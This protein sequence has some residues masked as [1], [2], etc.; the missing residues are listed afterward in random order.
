MNKEQQT[1]IKTLMTKHKKLIKNKQ[2]LT[3]FKEPIVFLIK[4]NKVTF[5]ENITE[6]TFEYKASNDEIRKVVLDPRYK[7]SF[8]YADKGFTGY[9]IDENHPTPIPTTPILSAES[10]HDVINRTLSIIDKW[11]A[12]DK[13]ATTQM[14]KTIGYITAGLIGMYILYRMMVQEPATVIQTVQN[15]TP[16]IIS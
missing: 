7:L 14:I 12:E 9:L 1:Q 3:E 10:F 5:H 13:K 4:G 16:T 2:A 8:D 15:I 6:G 11:K